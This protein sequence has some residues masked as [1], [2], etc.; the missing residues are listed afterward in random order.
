MVIVEGTPNRAIQ[1]CTKACATASAVIVVIGMAS[2]HH[3]RL[4]IH[5]SRYLNPS[6]GGRGPTR[7]MW[8]R[9]NRAPGVAN[10]ESGVTVCRWT[11]GRLT[12]EAGAS[13]LPRV[14]LDAWPDIID[15]EQSR[16]AA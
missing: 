6:E 5:V 8:T 16:G 9:S 11:F 7:S 2:G 4:S 10:V 14:S 13:P 3:V 15:S 12:L 1:Q